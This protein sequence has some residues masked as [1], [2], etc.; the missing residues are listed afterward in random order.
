MAY[1]LLRAIICCDLLVQLIQLSDFNF[2]AEMLEPEVE[3]LI[4]M[5]LFVFCF[6][7][8]CFVGGR[9]MVVGWFAWFFFI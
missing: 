5:E 3:Q 6:V 8:F 2:E 4:N 1:T 9:M 7:L